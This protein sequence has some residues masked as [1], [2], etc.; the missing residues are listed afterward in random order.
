MNRL[1]L[2]ALNAP[3]FLLLV[4]VAVAIQS[5]LFK[6]WPISYLQPDFVLIGVVWCG[7]KRPFLEASVLTL[8]FGEIAEIHSSAPQGVLSLCYVLAL[9]MSLASLKLLV[10]KGKRSWVLVT[11][12]G[13]LL[14]KSSFLFILYLL[15]LSDNQWRHTLLMLIPNAVST[16]LAAWFIFPYLERFDDW[17]WKSERIRKS[18]EGDLLLA[19]IDDDED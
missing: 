15:D 5:S 11:I 1:L 9:L 13:S 4:T 7:L 14:W 8:L 17:S 18:I 12:A 2:R 3:I 16:S 10:L 19:D 6:G